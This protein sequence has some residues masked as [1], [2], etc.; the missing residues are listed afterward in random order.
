MNNIFVVSILIFFSFFKFKILF[1]EHICISKESLSISIKQP[2]IYSDI[3]NVN[4]LQTILNSHD[5][6]STLF[7]NK[8]GMFIIIFI[9]S[10][11]NSNS[12]L[13]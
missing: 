3:I 4:I 10:L 8:Q 11:V 2:R 5:L 7:T 1:T 12:D 13:V 9:L 6:H